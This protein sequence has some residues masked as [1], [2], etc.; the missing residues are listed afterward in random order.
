MSRASDCLHLTFYFPER[1]D[2]SPEIGLIDA[3]DNEISRIPTTEPLPRLPIA[4]GLVREVDARDVL[5][6]VHDEQA[7]LAEFARILVPGGE[8]TV[9]VPL[10]NL[11]AWADALNIYRYISDI[12]GRGEHPLES[13]PTGW[14]RHYAPGD[15][16]AILE[17]AGFEPIATTTQGTPIEEV[18]QLLGLIIG[19]I[20]VPGNETER[21][22]FHLRR[23]L[24]DRPR[25]P[26][27][28]SVAS[29]I[30]V[31]ARLARPQYRPDPD[32]DETNRPEQ[33]ADEPL[34]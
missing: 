12:S 15:I 28:R 33:D 9:R 17:L 24:R 32:L 6:H 31:R 26:L 13:I 34:E 22:L 23:R 7:W 5:E 29:T 18:P 27:P 8:L 20:I 14:H 30:T 4:D 11:M 21:R 16:P 1:N 2:Q 10:E 3:L 25:V 19:K